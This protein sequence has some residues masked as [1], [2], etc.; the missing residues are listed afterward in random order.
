MNAASYCLGP[1]VAVLCTAP[2]CEAMT[3]SADSGRGGSDSGGT[4]DAP[5]RDTGPRDA[6]TAPVAAERL[7]VRVVRSVPHDRRAFTQGLELFE[8]SLLEGTGLYGRSEMRRVDLE[9]GAVLASVPLPA[10]VFGEGITRVGDRLYQLTWREERAFLRNVSDLS[11]I[12]E[13]AY[14]GEGWGLCHDG[15][16]LVMSD[17]SD[18]LFFRDPE[19]FALT[20]S[21]EVRLDGEPLDQLNELECV[22][23]IVYANVWQTDHIARIDA[24]S[25]RVTGW[26]DTAIH[27]ASPV[28][29]RL[30]PPAEAAGADVLNG[31][32]HLP[33]SG[34][35]LLG[36]KEWP[37]FF[38][39]ELVPAP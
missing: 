2:G 31:I 21:I 32:A 11:V 35:L 24:A 33:D 26:I 20:G 3:T 5:A 22:G 38:E 30:L 37:L 15:A 17:G 25:G 27:A 6:V 29:A 4:V 18:T 7:T 12:R 10:E 16:R 19:T 14:E 39:V 28:G 34:H 9:T 1:L 8:G 23:G 36:G 13:I